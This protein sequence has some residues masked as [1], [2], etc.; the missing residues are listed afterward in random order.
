MDICSFFFTPLPNLSGNH[1]L[2]QL[3]SGIFFFILSF[4]FFLNL[5][6]C[7]TDALD[8]LRGFLAHHFGSVLK[9]QPHDAVRIGKY[10]FGAAKLYKKKK[11]QLPT[12][13]LFPEIEG[14]Q[15][16]ATSNTII[17]LLI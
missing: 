7:L 17:H 15:L 10:E 12:H 2:R 9:C 16:S 13:W 11:K 1:V 5:W 14:D 4:S 6:I 3:R 8:Q